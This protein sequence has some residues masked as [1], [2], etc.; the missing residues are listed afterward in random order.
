MECKDYFRITSK[1]HHNDARK[2]YQE[3]TT[4]TRTISAV[5]FAPNS[6]DN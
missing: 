1:A 4:P 5:F 6:S 3:Q 2:D